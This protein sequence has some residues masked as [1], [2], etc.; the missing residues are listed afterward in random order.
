MRL[1]SESVCSELFLKLVANCLDVALVVVMRG[2]DV[3]AK[4][5]YSLRNLRFR[6]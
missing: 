1:R 2:S 4:V 3:N 6:W 5:F